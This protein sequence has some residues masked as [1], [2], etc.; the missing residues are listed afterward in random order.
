MVENFTQ[1]ENDAEVGEGCANKMVAKTPANF[2]ACLKQALN[3]LVKEPNP[4]TIAQL[5]NFSKN[6]HQ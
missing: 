4:K 1:K 5:L 2:E 6:L 3:K